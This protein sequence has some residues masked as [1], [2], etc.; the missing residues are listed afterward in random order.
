MKGKHGEYLLRL[1]SGVFDDPE[2]NKVS[3]DLVTIEIY[4]MVQKIERIHS[5]IYTQFQYLEATG[6]E[7]PEYYLRFDEENIPDEEVIEG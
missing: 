6:R 5:S 3:F 1:D 7:P 2:G 4:E